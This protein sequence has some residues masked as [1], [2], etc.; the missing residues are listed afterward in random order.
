NALKPTETLASSNID[1]QLNPW[2]YSEDHLPKTSGGEHQRLLDMAAFLHH[3]QDE[4]YGR[5]VKA[6]RAAGYKG[7]I[8]G[9]PWQAPSGL[10]NYYNLKSDYEA[11]Y[12]DR[13]NYFGGHVSDTMLSSPGSGYLSSGLQQV[14]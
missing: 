14:I 13:H 8:N 7:P 1:V 12:I 4:Y 3:C 2:F 5:F 10:P 9:S 11:G 6:I